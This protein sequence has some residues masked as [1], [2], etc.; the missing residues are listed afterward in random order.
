LILWGWVS[1]LGACQFSPDLPGET[2][3]PGSLVWIEDV[4]GTG[5]LFDYHF[6]DIV[7]Y[8]ITTGQRTRLTRDSYHDVHPSVAADGESVLFESVRIDPIG[9]SGESH[10]FEVTLQPYR[11]RQLST[12]FGQ[13]Y[14]R[15]IPND[16][17][18]SIPVAG[19]CH[20]WVAFR[21]FQAD[22]YYKLLVYDWARE[23]MEVLADSIHSPKKLRWSDDDSYLL[24]EYGQPVAPFIDRA[25]VGIYD[26]ETRQTFPLR[27]QGD[28]HLNLGGMVKDTLL[29]FGITLEGGRETRIY[30][31]DMQTGQRDTVTTFPEMRIYEMEYGAPPW[32][33]LRVGNPPGPAGEYSGSEIYAFNLQTKELI[34]LTDDGRQKSD[35]YYFRGCPSGEQGG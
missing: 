12:S 5:G 7:V 18:F 27:D 22:S 32:A 2:I 16:Y 20:P 11:L 29:L 4:D 26:R 6:G 31:Q 23:H 8:D 25:R 10:I 24:Y 33:Y 35:L 28:P 19:S 15:L 34:Q 3:S 13:T 9:L 30:L 14:E 17:S 21:A 1:V